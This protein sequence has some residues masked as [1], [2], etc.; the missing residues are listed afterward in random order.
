M[1]VAGVGAGVGLNVNPPGFDD[2][3]VVGADR[4]NEPKE[5]GAVVVV[6]DESPKVGGATVEAPNMLL[7][8]APNVEDVDG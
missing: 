6:V 1:V 7:E 2:A 8:G 3:V 4:L 5:S